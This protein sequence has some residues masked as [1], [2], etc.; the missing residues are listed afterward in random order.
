MPSRPELLSA[1]CLCP[2]KS[3]SQSTRFLMRRGT[4][5]RSSTWALNWPRLMQA[6]S[7][8]DPVTL[9]KTR[10]NTTRCRIGLSVQKCASERTSRDTISMRTP[11]SLTSR[12]RRNKPA[13]PGAKHPRSVHN[14]VS[15]KARPTPAPA[16]STSQESTGTIW[17]TR[18]LSNI[19]SVSSAAEPSRT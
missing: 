13:S 18:R 2:M 19:R 15:K 11:C 14:R 12:Q 16:H 4:P 10:L 5:A 7:R 8:L 3:H 17:L 9:S 6:K 1:S